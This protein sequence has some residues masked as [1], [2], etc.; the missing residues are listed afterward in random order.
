[1]KLYKIYD[2]YF[3]LYSFVISGFEINFSNEILVRTNR[4]NNFLICYNVVLNRS[5]SRMETS[6]FKLG[7]NESIIFE[8]EFEKLE[9]LIELI[10]EE[11]L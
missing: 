1:M 4:I 2:I 9:D 3:D 8:E 5:Y 6:E 11:F 7:L 10:P